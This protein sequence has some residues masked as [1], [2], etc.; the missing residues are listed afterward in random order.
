MLIEDPVRHFNKRIIG[1]FTNK[2]QQQTKTGK[3]IFTWQIRTQGRAEVRITWS[4]KVDLPLPGAPTMITTTG[5]PFS[6]FTCAPSSS[7]A[8]S[9]F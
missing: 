9:N 2:N 4:Q 8:I 5:F 1:E 3:K 6:T 7:F